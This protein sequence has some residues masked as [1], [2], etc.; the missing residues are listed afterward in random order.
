MPQQAVTSSVSERSTYKD[1]IAAYLVIVTPADN[2]CRRLVLH[3]WINVH[4]L[5]YLIKGHWESIG[6]AK[7]QT[8][9]EE[10]HKHAHLIPIDISF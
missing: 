5:G 1:A 6:V 10:I 3:T 8:K 2:R 7:D 9:K 4:W